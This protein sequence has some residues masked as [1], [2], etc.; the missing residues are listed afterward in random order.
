MI[1]QK[2]C[3]KK[4][5]KN[6]GKDVN[7]KVIHRRKFAVDHLLLTA[8]LTARIGDIKH[9]NQTKKQVLDLFKC[10]ECDVGGSQTA[11]TFLF[12]ICYT[13]SA[14]TIS[15]WLGS[16]RFQSDTSYVSER[17]WV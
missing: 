14:I 3:G 15:A 9:D 11:P 13:L 2:F 16:D 1:P 6:Q 7:M 4:S 12:A 10:Y 5:V 8:K 17:F